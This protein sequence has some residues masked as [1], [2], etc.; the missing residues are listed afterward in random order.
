MA[1][2]KMRIKL[3]DPNWLL[4]SDRLVTQSIEF[5]KGPQETHKGPIVTEFTLGSSQEANDAIAYLGRLIGNLPLTKVEQKIPKALKKA[6]ADKDPLKE[7]MDTVIAKSK[8]QEALINNLQEYGFKFTDYQFLCDLKHTEE[9]FAK[10]IEPKYHERAF[11]TRLI[12]E[13]KNPKNDKYDT[14]LVFIFELG[15]DRIESVPYYFFG[16]KKLIKLPWKDKKGINFKKPEFLF[17]FPEFMDEHER[18][19]WRMERKKVDADPNYKPSKIYTKWVKY[20]K[21]K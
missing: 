18:M 21:A 5:K 14:R 17:I 1:E 6:M 7:L 19:V 11:L 3:Y 16:E 8:T 10:M 4:L 15:R 13:A 9:G 20:V 2:T 12:K